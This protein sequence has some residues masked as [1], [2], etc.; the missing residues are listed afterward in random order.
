MKYHEFLGA[1]QNR[2]RLDSESAAVGAVR[3][4]LE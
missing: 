2:A 1:V 3:A 4:T